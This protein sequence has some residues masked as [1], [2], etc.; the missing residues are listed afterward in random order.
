VNGRVLSKF[1]WFWF[2]KLLPSPRRGMI[3]PGLHCGFQGQ[4]GCSVAHLRSACTDTGTPPHRGATGTRPAP[5]GAP[6]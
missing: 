1:G 4:A 2:L 6:H 3:G 5:L